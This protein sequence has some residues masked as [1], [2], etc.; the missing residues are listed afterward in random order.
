[1]N[2]TESML[3]LFIDFLPQIFASTRKSLS[4]QIFQLYYHAPVL[5]EVFLPLPVPNTFRDICIPEQ[6]NRGKF[7]HVCSPVLWGP[8]SSPHLMLGY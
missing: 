1:M 5:H 3:L 7:L 6:L 2:E 8:D 4:Q